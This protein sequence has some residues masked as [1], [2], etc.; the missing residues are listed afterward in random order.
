MKCFPLLCAL[1]L[2]AACTPTA[3]CGKVD[4]NA[5]GDPFDACDPIKPV[6]EAVFKFDLLADT[7]VIGPVAHAYH[8]IPQLGRTTID[9]VLTNLAEPANVLNSTLQGDMQA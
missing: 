8:H 1:L 7:Y 5:S 2:A 6:N 4:L 3:K 9:N